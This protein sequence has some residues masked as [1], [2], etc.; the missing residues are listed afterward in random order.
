L[1]LNSNLKV[2]NIGVCKL[3]G[4]NNEVKLYSVIQKEPVAKELES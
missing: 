3:R 4:K 2:D 1:N